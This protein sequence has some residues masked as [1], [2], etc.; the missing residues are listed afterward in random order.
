MNS[1]GTLLEAAEEQ[2]GGHFATRELTEARLRKLCERAK[3]PDET[4]EQITRISQ[5]MYAASQVSGRLGCRASPCLE[6]VLAAYRQLRLLQNLKAQAL[7]V[8]KATV[9]LLSALPIVTILLGELLGS[10]PL[11]FLFDQTR[12]LICLLLGICCYAVGL[13]WVRAL[14]REQA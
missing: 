11:E 4:P 7:A 8:P 1:G 10:R 3:L 5:S 6:V 9:S 12:G 2:Y 13:I 14:L